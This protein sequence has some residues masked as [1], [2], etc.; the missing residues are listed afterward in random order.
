MTSDALMTR[1]GSMFTIPAL[2]IWL[3]WQFANGVAARIRIGI[4][5]VVVLLG[6]L[7]LNTL[8]LKAYGANQR[9]AAIFLTR[10]AG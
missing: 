1:M 9:P 8:L 3:V 10:S 7:G 4:A 6:V 2:L 5:A